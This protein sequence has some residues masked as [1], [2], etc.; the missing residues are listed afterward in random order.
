MI[1]ATDCALEAGLYVFGRKALE[2]LPDMF[3]FG[4]TFP[5]TEDDEK[6]FLD[7]LNLKAIERFSRS[8]Q[9][10][11]AEHKEKARRK[12]LKL[13]LRISDHDL[14]NLAGIFEGIGDLYY[15]DGVAR[16]PE[17]FFRNYTNYRALVL[18][19]ADLGL[20]GAPAYVTRIPISQLSDLLYQEMT[21]PV[22]PTVTNSTPE[23][24]TI[25][26][27]EYISLYQLLKNVPEPAGGRKVSVDIEISRGTEERLLVVR[28][29]GPGIMDREGNPISAE[30]LPEIFGEYSSREGG[31]L[32]LQL[33]KA[34]VE[35]SSSEG[36]RAEKG[37]VNVSTRSEKGSALFY[38]TSEAVPGTL[39]RELARSGTEFRLYFRH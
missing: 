23:Y 20:G 24:K 10:F 30:R 16:M 22:I 7:T 38:S 25:N 9:E 8:V 13:A 35:L 5:V 4:I 31:G 14:N 27:R 11:A 2:I 1:A 17:P 21:E 15:K 12:N 6:T 32:G 18:A 34:L 28:D 26:S 39:E 33:V 19:M 3:R 36:R 37:Y 29:N